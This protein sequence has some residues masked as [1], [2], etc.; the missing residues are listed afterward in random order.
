MTAR[1]RSL[2][3][4]LIALL[5]ASLSFA[6][7]VTRV[8]AAG[9]L[10]EARQPQVAVDSQG[11]IYVAFGCGNTLY[12]AES[13]EGGHRFGAPVMV[14]EVPGLALGARRGPRI[15]VSKDFV[16]ITAACG[17]KE[18]PNEVDVRCWRSLTAGKTWLGPAPVNSVHGS[19]REGL[20]ALASGPTGELVCVWLDLR[21]GKTD[22]FGSLSDDGG[23]SWS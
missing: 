17:S 23:L 15:A 22:L 16:A 1:D 21:R 2:V 14:G 6:G 3:T 4:V 20:Q 8:V 7:E 5:A 11:R 13:E 9:V 12:C 10:R 19:G 18:S